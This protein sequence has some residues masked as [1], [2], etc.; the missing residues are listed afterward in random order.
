MHTYFQLQTLLAKYDYVEYSQGTRPKE[1]TSK[2][3]QP[4]FGFGSIYRISNV[5]NAFAGLNLGFVMASGNIGL[6]YRLNR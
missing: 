6:N 2:L 3:I 1:H 5:F 4:T